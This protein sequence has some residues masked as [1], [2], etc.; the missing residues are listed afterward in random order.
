MRTRILRTLTGALV[1]GGL[2][3]SLAACSSDDDSSN[4]STDA[5]PT[6]VATKFGDVEVKEKPE[7]VVA[8]GWGD[9]ETAVA[10]GVQPV[11]ASDWAGY[12]DDGLGPWVED[13]YDEAPEIISTTEPEYEIADND[14]WKRLPAV[15]NG[16]GTILPKE[17]V[18]AFSMGT[19]QAYAYGMDKMLPILEKHVAA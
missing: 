17:V 19:A 11:A 18:Q 9:A 7:K 13:G 8:I 6:T 14:A 4:S 5:F 3:I 15:K 2:A 12:G 1:A 10:L 16:H